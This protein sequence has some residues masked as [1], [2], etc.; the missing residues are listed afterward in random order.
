M[1][2]AKEVVTIRTRTFLAAGTIVLTAGCGGGGTAAVNQPAHASASTTTRAQAAPAANVVAQRMQLPGVVTYTAATDP[3]NLLGR[4]RE[5]TSKAS[6]A[7]YAFAT[8]SGGGS[9]EVF[10]TAADAHARLAYLQAFQPPIGDGYDYLTDTAILRL[11]AD[12]TPAQA[13]VLHEAFNHAVSP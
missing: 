7:G 13:Q 10:P 4:Q 5:Y 8:K 11:S 2:H 3:N 12:Y 6:W 9:I 1:M